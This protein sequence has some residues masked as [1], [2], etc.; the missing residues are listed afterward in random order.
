M[1]LCLPLGSVVKESPCNE[2][3]LGSIP[4]LG[5]HAH[6]DMTSLSSILAW[7][8]SWTEEPSRLQSTGS[9]KVGHFWIHW[10]CIV[11]HTYI[12]SFIN[13]YPF[14]LLQNFKQSSLWFVVGP[15]WLCILYL[16]VSLY[17]LIPSSQF[18][19]LPQLSFGNHQLCF[20]VDVFLMF[21]RGGSLID[22]S[23]P[24]FL[25]LLWLPMLLVSHT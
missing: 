25:F 19:P 24:T 4:G 10:A 11:T 17:M 6:R 9:Q 8:I 21:F 7:R 18:L 14:L 3:D 16:V 5:R 15:C 20:Y 12:C 23:R 1:Y 2:G 22:W 13:S